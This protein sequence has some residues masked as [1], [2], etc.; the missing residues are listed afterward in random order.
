MNQ[1][2][3]QQAQRAVLGALLVNSAPSWEIVSKFQSSL[4]FDEP[5]NS[6]I[7]AAITRCIAKTGAATPP[8]VA[9][10]LAAAGK[11][12]ARRQQI[13]ADLPSH[14]GS[15]TMSLEMWIQH[16]IH[17]SQTRDIS[18]TLRR[19]TK[20]INHPQP[21]QAPSDIARSA[22]AAL[23]VSVESFTT[24]KKI[25]WNLADIE[26]EARDR[27]NLPKISTGIDEIND[28]FG[29]GFSA[30]GIFV[31]GGKSGSGKTTLS[32]QIANHADHA[33]VVAN[34]MSA[35]M[36]RSLII[37]QTYGEPKCDWLFARDVASAVH[38]ETIAELWARKTKPNSARVFI[39]DMVQSIPSGHES[40]GGN[41]AQDITNTMSVLRRIAEKTNA[42]VIINAAVVKSDDNPTLESLRD[43]GDLGYKADGV[44]IINDPHDYDDDGLRKVSIVKNRYGRGRGKPLHLSISKSRKFAIQG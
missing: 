26:R 29:G 42:A 31:L 37:A 12:N 28:I 6:V 7:F 43:G 40:E 8:L 23:N 41:K 24:G 27:A 19:A 10:F 2:I 13:L 4:R 25:F 36:L 9:E 20:A 5:D 21:G 33:L 17:D 14:A 35:V 16:I 11:L 22:I 30:G 15:T 34:D 44:I 3:S 18:E 1:T 38:A 39:I 32:C